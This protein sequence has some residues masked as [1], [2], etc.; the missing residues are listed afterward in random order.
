[1]SLL[2]IIQA[3]CDRI[4]L[5]RP[6]QVIG[7]SDQQTRSLFGLTN[8]E[9]RELATRFNWQALTKEKTF[10]TVAAAAQ[11]GA[12]PSDFD[13]FIDGT[14]W[15]RTTRDLIV[16][17]MNAQE[18]QGMQATVAPNVLKG[19]R[20]RGS[21]ILLTPTPSAGQTVAYE[22]VSKWWIGTAASTTAT[23][24]E[25]AADT[26]IVYL[27][28][29]IIVLGVVWRFLRSRGLDY[30]EA[31]RSYELAVNR[32]RARDGGSPVLVM[33]G[34]SDYYRAPKAQVPDGSW[35]LT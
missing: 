34:P 28:D 20:V 11:T 21:D 12:V 33:G 1:M 32:E 25:F 18:W 16:G 27:K 31:F 3:A 30:S 19:F 13:R 8:Q 22:Y 15:N 26:D 2:T 6:S 5:A 35:N 9:G 24:D 17:P 29:E 14:M 23:L 4:G 7:S 10:T